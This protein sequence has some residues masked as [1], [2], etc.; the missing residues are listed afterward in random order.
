MRYYSM[1]HIN[2]IAKA[3]YGGRLARP[4][5][6][7][8]EAERFLIGAMMIGVPV[9]I[10]PRDFVSE[11][12]RQAAIAISKAPL[13]GK[14][15]DI[16]SVVDAMPRAD[17]QS[18]GDI[19]N[20]LVGLMVA[21][22]AEDNKA[23]R[24]AR[25]RYAVS[26]VKRAASR[27][28]LHAESERLRDLAD[29]NSPE[30]IGTELAKI[31]SRLADLYSR[32]VPKS[33]WLSAADMD[34]GDFELDYLIPGLLAKAQPSM[35]FGPQKSLKTGTAVDLVLSLATGSRFLGEFH[36][37]GRWNAGLI[38]GESG[39]ATIQETA[40]RIARSKGWSLRQIEGAYFNFNI[41]DLLNPGAVD[42]IRRFIQE[43]ELA[44]LVIDPVYLAM[45]RV[46]ES[47]SNVF[48]M[49]EA[50]K[51]IGNLCSETGCTIVLCH[52]TKKATG[53]DYGPPKMEDVAF[54]GFGEF[55]RQWMMLKRREAYDP[56]NGGSH[57]LWFE[58][59][60]SAGHSGRWGLNIEEGL[61]SD[62]GGR[63]WDVEVVSSR[64]C[65][66]ESARQAAEERENRKL[67]RSEAERAARLNKVRVELL[68]FPDGATKSKIREAA[69]VQSN[70]IDDLLSELIERDEAESCDVLVSNR[71]TP[72]LGFRPTKQLMD[73]AGNPS[74]VNHSVHS[75]NRHPSGQ[76]TAL[77]YPPLRGEPGA[78]VECNDPSE[79]NL[80]EWPNFEF[81]G[82]Q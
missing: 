32:N 45:A 79:A 80:T 34:A 61:R 73:N 82:D 56:E 28:A 12:C 4:G 72:I 68:G 49:G 52:H 30:H 27:R 57:R 58:V 31:T 53:A 29:G 43:N 20:W 3:D 38:S 24:D 7:V 42:A 47:A 36:I 51:P 8:E 70:Q 9:D 54:A 13:E 25:I 37:N 39:A 44:C 65:E 35:K 5:D 15:P 26:A 60:G 40:R 33:Q 18:D 64:E 41:P 14:I 81:E 78:V 23:A 74:N 66:V 2:G 67:D 22:P 46:A 62:Q 11:Q 21:V 19:A 6:D 76:P 10:S 17:G 71:K 59:G 75:V 69:K 63:R 50:L 16:A 1:S 48:S 55:A 77:G